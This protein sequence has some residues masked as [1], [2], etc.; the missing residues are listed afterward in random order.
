MRNAETQQPP[1]DEHNLQPESGSQVE[2]PVRN[3]ADMSDLYTPD[4]TSL[5][6]Q[7]FEL[8]VIEMKEMAKPP[9][10]IEADDMIGQYLKDVART[11][12]LSTEEITEHVRRIEN[13]R[14]AR[15]EM[16]RGSVKPKRREHLK[17]IIRDAHEAQEQFITANAKL[18]ISVAKKYRGR[19]VEFTDLIQEGNI[20]LIRAGKKFDYRRG[21]RFST[22]ATWW[23]RQ[24]ILRTI[25]DDGRT[26][27]IPS[28]MGEHITT[29]F[30]AQRVLAQRLGRDPTNGELA[31]ELE[32]T[33]ESVNFM[34][35]ISDIPRSLDEP[36][37]EEDML[38]GDFLED[39]NPDI[40]QPQDAVAGRSLRD[41]LN[42]MLAGLPLR[43]AQ[44][45]ALRTGLK[46][47]EPHTLEEVGNMYGVSR[48]RIRQI[49]SLALSRLRYN[50]ENR[51]KLSD[52]LEG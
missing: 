30:R 38:L 24:A 52:Y 12:M 43:E 40:P 48:E 41:R 31:A 9:G 51:R 7:D 35:N 39:T 20:G 47:G 11:P 15:E 19:G 46:D 33:T 42:E 37:G 36:A 18:V 25:A 44:I 45:L 10:V 49:E 28:H 17:H 5:D 4:E 23:I 2:F 14:A 32:I 22:Y 1:S 8:L 6:P 34:K 3:P 29:M 26:I 50:K 13:G 27:R 16:T 21:F